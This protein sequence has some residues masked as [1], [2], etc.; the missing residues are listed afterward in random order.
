[1]QSPMQASQ[2]RRFI[3]LGSLSVL[4]VACAFLMGATAG[5]ALNGHVHSI[6]VARVPVAALQAAATPASLAAVTRK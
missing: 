4:G 2:I 1:M 3:A 5:T 6:S